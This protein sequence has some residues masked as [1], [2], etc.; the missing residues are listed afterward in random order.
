MGIFSF[1]KSNALVNALG[2]KWQGA[3]NVYFVHKCKNDSHAKLLK[4]QFHNI[5][6]ENNVFRLKTNKNQFLFGPQCC[7]SKESSKH[8]KQDEAHVRS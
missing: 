7:S 4:F 8:L 2:N 3:R 6:Y 5:N 1:K